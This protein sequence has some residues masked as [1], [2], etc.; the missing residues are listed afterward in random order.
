MTARSIIALARAGLV[1]NITSAGTPAAW[2]RARLAVQE[3]G[4]YSARSM[5]AYSRAPA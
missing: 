3:R 1:A 4:R 2:H 5:K